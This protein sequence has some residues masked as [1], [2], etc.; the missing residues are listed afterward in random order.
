MAIAVTM[1]LTAMNAALS[2]GICAEDEGSGSS[3]TSG[4]YEND[5]AS[6]EPLDEDN[7]F[8]EVEKDENIKVK[9]EG[10]YFSFDQ[11]PIMINDR[12]MVPIR[13]LFEEMGY[14]VDWNENDQIATAVKGNEKI[15][16]KLNNSLI[17]CENAATDYSYCDVVPQIVS[18]RMLVPLR[19]FAEATGCHVE[20]DGKNKTVIAYNWQKVT[21]AYMQLLDEYE[22]QK[23]WIYDSYSYPKYCV[24]DI[25]KNGVPELIIDENKNAAQK[26]MHI[27]TYNL[28]NKEP[29]YLGSEESGHSSLCSVPNEN[30][31]MKFMAYMDYEYVDIISIA[32]EELEVNNIISGKNCK[33]DYST[34]YDES[35]DIVAG[36]ER[37]TYSDVNNRD[38]LYSYY[39]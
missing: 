6:E 28:A 35:G 3:D 38:E 13:A 10:Q 2:N 32:S 25:D 9:V 29:K 36:S 12:V 1:L 5:D 11:P 20:W 39:L 7:I 22:N 4:C 21:E 26:K 24:Y 14:S 18:G 19:A 27:Y 37:L 8:K 16:V 17:T 23:E 31:I 34:E 30:G 15:H 33:K